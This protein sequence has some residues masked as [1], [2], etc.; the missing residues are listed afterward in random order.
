MG[1]LTFL[2]MHVE[3]R[4]LKKLVRYI[5]WKLPVPCPKEYHLHSQQQFT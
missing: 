1:L 3:A 5:Y 4:R 2:G